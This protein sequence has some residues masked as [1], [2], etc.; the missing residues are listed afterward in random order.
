MIGPRATPCSVEDS[1]LNFLQDLLTESAEPAIET[2]RS[3]FNTSG[4]ALT[5]ASVLALGSLAQAFASILN[6]V[7]LVYD[8]HD[9]RGW[10]R[11]RWLGLLI[12]IGSVLTLVIVVTLVV[13]GSAVR[14]LRTSCNAFGP[15]RRVR[16][17]VVL[18]ALARRPVRARALGDDDVPRLP[19]PGGSVASV[20]SRGRC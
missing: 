20:G 18:P 13:I 14:R 19:R 1:V 6:T 16:R 8:V 15:G 12:G 11:R 4:G 17:A 2:A 3:L 7:T 5:L 10:W 9:T